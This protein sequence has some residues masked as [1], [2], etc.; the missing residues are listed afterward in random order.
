MDVEVER[1]LAPHHLK[2]RK[3]SRR[4]KEPNIKERDVQEW[5]SI[6]ELNKIGVCEADIGLHL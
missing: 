4:S 6:E 1:R 5:K 2:K 3:Q